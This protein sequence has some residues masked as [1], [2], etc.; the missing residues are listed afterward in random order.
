MVQPLP[1]SLRIRLM[2][3]ADLPLGMALKQKAGWNQTEADWHRFLALQPDG[4]FLAEL[5]GSGV[6]TV[7]VFVFGPVAWVAMVLVDPTVRGQGIGTALM[8]HAL[9]FLDRQGVCSI[10]L[11]ATDL[12]RPIYEKLG[13]SAEYQ[14]AR[15]EGRLPT[16]LALGL[17]PV[18]RANMEAVLKLDHAAT[19]TDRG[20]LLRLLYAENPA[21]FRL[22][23][24]E[25]FLATRPGARA[26]QIGPCS[27]SAAAGARLFADAF[28]SLA[29]EIV[30]LDIPLGNAEPLRLAESQ[31]LAVQ[32]SFW[33][34]TRGQPVAEQVE[35]IW[36]SSGPEK[37]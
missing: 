31:G 12:G 28:C 33:R 23:E 6:G 18:V 2:T 14:L 8:H 3:E 10:R 30:Y 25:G 22:V 37:G 1:G 16:S 35:R 13:F 29:G 36:A 19:G 24:G 5:D 32:R 26:W 9:D 34:M 17:G 15:Y 20:R 11:D 27:T 21:A 7:A 4:C